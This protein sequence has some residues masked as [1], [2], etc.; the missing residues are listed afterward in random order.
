[1]G[2]L[3]RSE[4]VHKQIN[5]DTPWKA[6]AEVIQHLAPSARLLTDEYPPYTKAAREAGVAH[7]IVKHRAEEYVH[8]DVHVNS[9][10]GYWSQLKRQVYGIHHWVSRKHLDRYVWESV[11]RF[12]CRALTETFPF[13]ELLAMTDGSRL[14]YPELIA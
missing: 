5:V 13:N 4:K 3:E 7:E 8:G 14:I 9:I 11:W 1:M 2:I 10:E 6:A 12:N